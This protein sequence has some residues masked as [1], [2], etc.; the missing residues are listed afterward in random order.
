VPFM[1]VCETL[2]SD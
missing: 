1:N 2:F